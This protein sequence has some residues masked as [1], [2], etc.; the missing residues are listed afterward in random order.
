M[1]N[2][3]KFTMSTGQLD[4]FL[5]KIIDLVSID[6]EVLLKVDNKNLLIYSLVGERKSVNAFKSYIFKTE[7]VLTFTDDFPDG[8][9]LKYIIQDGKRFEVT[10]R[11]F[12]DFE[13]D[14]QC[15]MFM[16]SAVQADSWSLK[17]SDLKLSL[18]GGDP[19][20]LNTDID[21]EKIKDTVDIN[22]IDF[23]FQLQ[24][25]LFANIKKMSKIETQENDI[26]YLNI[27]NNTLSIGETGWDLKICS[28]E[29]EDMSITFPKRFFNSINF[30]SEPQITIYV[31]DTFLFVD[32]QNTSL[33]IA[34]ELSV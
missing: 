28:I 31:F 29:H 14:I 17:N 20:G 27:L 18:I 9:V 4:F 33:L 15:E 11:N 23:K 12:L 16:N 10:L 26:L 6:K 1:A 3:Y 5:D 2:S 30:T 22:N 21:A 7:E 25:S 32:N 19:S 13:Q 34:L 24:K 8:Q